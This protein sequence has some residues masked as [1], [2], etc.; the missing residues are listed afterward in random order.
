MKARFPAKGK[1]GEQIRDVAE[2]DPNS[3]MP[4]V[5]RQGVLTEEGINVVIEYI[6]TL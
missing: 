2:R 4:P 1:L 3:M 6:Q 5:G